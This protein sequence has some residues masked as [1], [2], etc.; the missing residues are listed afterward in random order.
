[1]RTSPP[2]PP[3]IGFAVALL[4]LSGAGTAGLRA[5]DALDKAKSL[6]LEA[7]YE[8]AL[9]VLDAS[10]T[11]TTA[12]GYLYRA[13][14][15]LALGRSAEA[16][17]AITRSIE[18]DPQATAARQD[19]S[20]RVAAV[21]ADARR[22]ALPDVAKRRVTEG[23]L[24]FQ[25]GDKAAAAVQFTSA[26][27][28]LD[29]PVLANQSELQDLKMLASGFLDLIRAQTPPPTLAAAPAAAPA[30]SP[31]A[32]SSPGPSSPASPVVAPAREPVPAS[33]PVPAPGPTTAATATTTRPTPISQVMPAWR[34][35]DA[36]AARQ[37]L[38]GSVL[39]TIDP[40][41]R[42]TSAVMQQ[43]VHPA[44]DRLLLAAA[45]SWRYQ[46]ALRDGQPISSQLVVPIV[47][48]AR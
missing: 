22:R 32:T 24:L 45:R 37:A 20:P 12:D 11:L 35:P 41:G 30:A 29:D 26:I 48:Q 8:D 10:T 6:Y 4:L 47:V 25:K 16:D 13:L 14:C 46:P 15:L 21:V 27:R 28:V 17:A 1:M 3:S 39:I 18:V 40:A 7:A 44:Y 38:R 23:R 43:V 9:A 2:L 36:N 33:G 19:L 42:V 34:P 31:A 5:Q